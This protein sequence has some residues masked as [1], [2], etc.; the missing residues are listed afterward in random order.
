LPKAPHYQDDL[1]K[2]RSLRGRTTD[3]E[4][5]LWRSLR[6]RQLGGAKFRRQHPI[7]GYVVDFYCQEAYLAVEL[8]GGQHVASDMNRQDERRTAE[9]M[10]KG[11]RLLRFWDNEVL[12]NERGVLQK[13]AEAIANPS[14]PPSPAGRGRKTR[15]QINSE[16]IANP[17]PQPSPVGRGRKPATSSRA[18]EQSP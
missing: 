12:T 1:A 3:A 11:I 7:G 14:P 18:R 8:D 16:A 4:R 17:S 15:P 10:S 13:I 9:L 6:N 2:A 5:S